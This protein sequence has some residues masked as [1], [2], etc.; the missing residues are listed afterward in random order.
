MFRWVPFYLWLARDF[1]CL[2]YF[3]ARFAIILY[4]LQ[5]VVT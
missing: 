3:L 5:V 2:L 1:D 4:Y